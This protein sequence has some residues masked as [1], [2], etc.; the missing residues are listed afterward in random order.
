MVAASIAE[1]LAFIQ[2]IIVIYKDALVLWMSVKEL[3]Y[4]FGNWDDSPKLKLSPE[5]LEIDSG[6]ALEKLDSTL[7]SGKEKLNHRSSQ[8][9]ITL[10][11]S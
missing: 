6:F 7:L 2:F 8:P 10:K 9:K 5:H 3:Q 4:C 11:V 1:S